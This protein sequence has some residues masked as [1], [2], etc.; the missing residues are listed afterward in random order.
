MKREG[1]CGIL[2]GL[3]VDSAA[4][5]EGFRG[6]SFCRGAKDCGAARPVVSGRNPPMRTGIL[7]G[8]SE[9]R[10]TERRGEERVLCSR[11]AQ[12]E[13]IGS[14]VVGAGDEGG[15]G[16]GDWAGELGWLE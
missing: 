1:R 2:E 3:A 16:L 15:E 13:G 11:A 5:V 14:A 12:S 6:G 8:G 4:W 10:E 9:G 7:E